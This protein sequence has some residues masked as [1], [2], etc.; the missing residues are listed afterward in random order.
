MVN[1]DLF[2][3]FNSV[4]FKRIICDFYMF[5]D[6]RIEICLSKKIIIYSYSHHS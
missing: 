6:Y 3:G 5:I 1:Y 4:F 2:G